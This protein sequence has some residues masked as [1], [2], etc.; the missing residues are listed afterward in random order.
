MSG[1]AEFAALGGHSSEHQEL[2]LWTAILTFVLIVLVLSHLYR[3]SRKRVE[4][5]DVDAFLR[6]EEI[7]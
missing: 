1:R 7:L 5:E 4:M 6:E 3:K 2:V